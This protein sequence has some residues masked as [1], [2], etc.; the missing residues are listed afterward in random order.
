MRRILVTGSRGKSSI[1]RL[2]HTAMT[3]A[4]LQSWA[5]ITGVVPR[6]LGPG[7]VHNILRSSGAHVE[8]MRWWLQQLPLSAQAVILE[9][10]AISPDL[11]PLAGRWLKPDI[12]VFSNALPDHQ[13]AWGPTRE[14]AAE[15]LVAGIPR[16]GQVVLPAGLENDDYLARLLLN[17][18]CRLAYAKAEAEA[19]EVHKAVNLGLSLAALIRLGIEPGDARK[20]MLA[21]PEDRYDFRVVQ[22]GGAEFAMAF[23]V[24]DI[25]STRMLFDTLRWAKEETRLVYN[26]RKDRPERFASF[27]AWLA[28]SPWKEVLVIGDRPRSRPE[29]SRYRKVRNPGE[30][31]ALFHPGER[32]FGCGNI[33]GL[34]LALF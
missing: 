1:V 13:E 8:E 20:A 34:P 21:L 4:G 28:Q 33:A 9:N 18:G 26:H 30:L 12:T 27:F 29:S 6:E 31:L 3:D 32:V 11:Q 19:G 25:G 10:S 2:L 5:R 22:R 7:G 23:S 17:R 15:V 24:N 14:S 16:E